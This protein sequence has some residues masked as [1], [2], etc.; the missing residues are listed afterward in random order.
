M[1]YLTCET[2]S[3]TFCNQEVEYLIYN[4]ALYTQF[5]SNLD[6]FDITVS[7]ITV[8]D[9]ITSFTEVFD[10]R[11]NVTVCDETLQNYISVYRKNYLHDVFVRVVDKEYGACTGINIP[12]W[13]M[14]GYT[15]D[16]D[17]ITNNS[18]N[19]TKNLLLN[20]TPYLNKNNMNVISYVFNSMNYLESIMLKKS[21]VCIS[22]NGNYTPP[23]DGD[24]GNTTPLEDAEEIYIQHVD[25][26]IHYQDQTSNNYIYLKGPLVTVSSNNTYKLETIDYTKPSLQLFSLDNDCNIFFSEENDNTQ[27]PIIATEQLELD[28]ATTSNHMTLNQDKTFAKDGYLWLGLKYPNTTPSF[29]NNKFVIK[30][31]YRAPSGNKRFVIDVDLSGEPIV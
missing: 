25:N 29:I 3:L 26:Y 16:P 12:C 14:K 20:S 31:L 9:P 22:L 17:L 11:V 28:Y 4:T 1:S 10:V 2:S 6:D 8:S 19:S 24:G 23:D 7:I 21:S 5:T 13:V 18:T 27:D 30:V 15:T